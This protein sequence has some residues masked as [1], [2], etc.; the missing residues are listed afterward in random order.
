VL[1]NGVTIAS[2]AATAVLFV[3][4][5]ASAAAAPRPVHPYRVFTGQR[6]RLW[7]PPER[8]GFIAT[9]ATI[10]AVDSTGLTVVIKDRTELIAFT[11]LARMD[12]RRGWRH[13]RRGALVGLVV[14]AAAGLLAED[15]GDGEDKLRA[16]ALYGGV[17]AAVGAITAGAIW[18][19]RWVPVDLDQIR[20]QPAADRAA[21]RLSFTFSF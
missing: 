10:T 17:G 9:K 2:R 19:A 6:V 21:V 11:D 4:A 20:P 8:G 12:V 1:T 15:G 16:G 13:L 7:T 18:P 14:G 5:A 3:A